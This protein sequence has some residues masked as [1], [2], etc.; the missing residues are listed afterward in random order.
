ML[1]SFLL[2]IHHQELEHYW[3]SLNNTTFMT[4]KATRNIKKIVR[5]DKKVIQSFQKL[6]VTIFT[7]ARFPFQ[8]GSKLRVFSLIG[9]VTWTCKDKKHWL[10]RQ[11]RAKLADIFIT[12]NTTILQEFCCFNAVDGMKILFHSL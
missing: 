6:C 4:L 7:K 12:S 11:N 3:S 2:S 8:I 1:E 9:V 5:D 10:L